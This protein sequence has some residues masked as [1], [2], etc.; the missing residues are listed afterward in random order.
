MKESLKLKR[1]AAKIKT[2]DKNEEESKEND[3]K[4]IDASKV[5]DYLASG[6]RDRTIRIWEVK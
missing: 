5:R 4:V 1:E 2:E 6:S 3:S